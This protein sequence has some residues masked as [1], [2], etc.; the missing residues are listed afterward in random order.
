MTKTVLPTVQ[1]SADPLISTVWPR[2][3]DD[4]VR[5]SEGAEAITLTAVPRAAA[6]VAIRTSVRRMAPPRSIRLERTLRG[7]EPADAIE[8]RG[9]VEAEREQRKRIDE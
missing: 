9:Q 7:D 8:L 3:T 4:G 1:P 6:R 2:F 5:V